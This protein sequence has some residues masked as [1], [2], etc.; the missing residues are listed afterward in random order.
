M[1]DILSA[2]QAAPTPV[3][4]VIIGAGPVGL[5]Q[6]FELSLLGIN[7]HIIDSLPQVGGQ[8]TELYPEKPIYDIPAL[9]MCGAQELVDRL[10]EQAKPFNAGF[11]LGQEIT[12][13]RKQD[14]GRF[15]VASSTGTRFD[16]ATVIIAGGVGSFQPR[17]L[18]VPDAE[19]HE[20]K[21][22]HY[23]VKTAT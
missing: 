7:A 15:F 21:N 19:P 10:L 23:R 11:H 22:I 9:P 16:A 2:A 6:I 12:E 5:F 3:E 14:D 8:C 4:V 13:V 1:S 20:G 17:R 18:G